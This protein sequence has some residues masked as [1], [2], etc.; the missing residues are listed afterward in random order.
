MA[1]IVVAAALLTIFTVR[2]N[3]TGLIM[4]LA[5]L[6]ASL[7]FVDAGRR[8]FFVKLGWIPYAWIALC[9]SPELRF[10]FR[11]ALDTSIASTGLETFA[12]VG[13]YALVALLVVRTRRLLVT[14]D[15]RT[16]R[17]GP[18]AA[19]PLL[20]LIS[21]MWS[22]IPLFT[23]VRSLQLFAPIGLAIVMVRIW[24]SSPSLA[25]SLWRD[26]L[27]FFVRTVTFLTLVGIATS[28][29]SGI[30]TGY[31]FAWPGT[32]PGVV[33]VFCATA[34]LILVAS[35][36]SYLGVR[37]SGF[38]FRVL[39]FASAIYL[40]QTRAVLAAL[41]VAIAVLIWWKGRTNPASRYIGA[42]YYV[43]AVTLV[44]FAAWD[45]IL[46]YL[47][48]GASLQ[49]NLSL[50]GRLPLWGMAI[51][52][53]SDADR[54]LIGFGYGSGRVILPLHAEWA[55]TAHN[56]WIELLMSIGVVG[57]LL[58]AASL[59]FVL[60]HAPSIGSIA[61][62]PLALSVL[63]LLTVTSLTGEQFALPGMGF[64]LLALMYVPVLVTRNVSLPG[65]PGSQT[66]R[67]GG[68]ARSRPRPYTVVG[69]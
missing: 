45:Q 42:F 59:L 62:P 35:G 28:S 43:V 66:Y 52:L 39:L 27:R 11:S 16:I 9:F 64:T 20:A 50:T 13:I 51:D 44:S 53:I 55:G 2:D 5:L 3:R 38:V 60:R 48:R 68:D 32:H 4:A 26:T 17:K 31:R 41:A 6:V 69:S 63:A 10:T 18:L 65:T 12:Q 57:P 7:V 22:P 23:L 14:A 54:W 1:A 36:R 67:R 47:E 15:P 40:S 8:D 24:L 34:L 61:S 49:E 19:W 46:R 58:L 29:Q 25:A 56:S 30:G 37:L 21:T 33:A